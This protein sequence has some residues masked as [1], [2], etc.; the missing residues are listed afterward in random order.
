MV[1]TLKSF[2]LMMF[3]GCL[4]L[5][6]SGCVPLIIGAAAGAG[7]VAYVK[8][9][10]EKNFDKPVDDIHRAGVRA[11]KKLKMTIKDDVITQHNAKVK[12]VDST[13][14]KV[15]LDIEAL[16]EKAAKLRI[17]VGIFGDQESSQVILNA[18]QRQL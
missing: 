11:L 9:G 18:I 1:K 5:A 17:R 8:G 2:G 4:I 16:T 3:L 14:K 12:A 10:L 15:E 6:A 7:G 13:G